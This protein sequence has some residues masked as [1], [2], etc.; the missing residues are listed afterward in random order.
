ML[1]G[2]DLRGEQSK[3]TIHIP[4]GWKNNPEDWDETL[5]CPG[6]IR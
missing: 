2:A 3:I 6:G 4:P 1:H 5:V